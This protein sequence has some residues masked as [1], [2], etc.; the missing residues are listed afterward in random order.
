M[1]GRAFLQ[2]PG[3]TNIPERVLRSMDRSVIDHRGPE[4]AALTEAVR[5]G[6]RQVFGTEDGV[7]MLYPG[8][9][10]GA[11]EAALVNV[12]SPGERVLVYNYGVFSGGLAMMARKFGFEVDEVPLG[13][14]KTIPLDDLEARLKADSATRPYRAVL[15]VHNE[16]STGVTIDVAGVRG[17]M[18]AAQ[19]DALLI[20]DTVSSLASIEFLMDA[21]RVDVAVCGSQKGLM[22]PPGLGILCA[23][24][25]AVAISQRGGSPRHFW[26]W[27]PIMRENRIG[28]FPYTP[29]TL[30]LF[31]LREALAMLVDE[32]GLPSVYARHARLASAV[33]AAVQGWE[34]PIVCEDPTCYSNTITT[35]R[36]PEGI[37]SNQL[38]THARE[39]YSL[40]L[41]GGIGEL[42]GVAF[43]IGH[44]GALNEL[45]VLATI[46]GCEL[47]FADLGMG[48]E[49]GSG[50]LACQR[51][52]L[53]SAVREPV[54]V[55]A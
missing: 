42:S 14:G 47:T 37:D 55:A 29:A 2:I 46:A 44:L 3:P 39:R 16:T 11:I 50:L 27:A 5:V 36:V 22:L 21:W 17:A 52:F 54:G 23:S 7:P 49:P 15:V 53:R 45:E 34:L 51:T 12:L 41:G 48:V 33:R 32:E 35:V 31:G 20:V 13:Y 25:R 38:T 8:S 40:S 28:L 30:M 4:F 10:T 24:P 43:R 19:H 9:G 18:D 1:T 6:L 26:D